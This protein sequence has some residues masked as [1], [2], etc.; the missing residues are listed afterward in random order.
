MDNIKSALRFP[1]PP[2]PLPPTPPQHNLSSRFSADT[3][4]VKSPPGAKTI[5]R[6][7]NHTSNAQPQSPPLR[8]FSLSSSSNSTTRPKHSPS[9][10]ESF[11]IVPSPRMYDFEVAP[12][13][14]TSFDEAEVLRSPT[15]VAS[16]RKELARE[17]SGADLGGVIGVGKDRLAGAAKEVLEV[18]ARKRQGI[19]HGRK[20]SSSRSPSPRK[21]SVSPPSQN[22]NLP[23][24]SSRPSIDSGGGGGIVARKLVDLPPRSDSIAGTLIKNSSP[25]RTRVAK[26]TPSPPKPSKPKLRP[27]SPPSISIPPL[28][29]H[30]RRR[31]NPTLPLVDRSLPPFDAL[32]LSVPS[33][34]DLESRNSHEILVQIDVGGSSHTTTVDTLVGGE[35]KG[36]RL[37]QLV[38]SKIGEIKRE[39]PRAG[40]KENPSYLSLTKF[41]VEDED[42][43]LHSGSS[44]NITGSH[45]EVSP[46]PSPFPFMRD[47]TSSKDDEEDEGN[48][49]CSPIDPLAPQLFLSMPSF[50]APPP[51]LKLDLD[52]LPASRQVQVVPTP[53]LGSKHLSV[54]PTISSNSP[55]PASA[56]SSPQTPSLAR[57]ASNAMS[58]RSFSYHDLPLSP[59]EIAVR[60]ALKKR[61]H[62]STGSLGFNY[63][64]GDDD[65]S[66]REPFFQLLQNQAFEPLP[67]RPGSP[68]SFLHLQNDSPSRDAG[69]NG[70]ETIVFGDSVSRAKITEESRPRPSVMKVETRGEAPSSEASSSTRTRPPSLTTSESTA[71]TDS[72]FPPSHAP[73]PSTSTIPRLHVFLDRT[74]ITLPSGLGTTYSTILSFLRDGVLPP[75]LTLPPP[76][77]PTAKI[78]STTLSIL[79]VQPALAFGQLAALRTVETEAKWVEIDSLVEACAAERQKWIEALRVVE[80]DR[81]I[82]DRSFGDTKRKRMKERE[83]EGWI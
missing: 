20:G 4:A 24:K 3:L 23:E 28:N 63:E 44:I 75:F 6:F 30:P 53:S 1:H 59:D 56:S 79:A 72:D 39:G 19:A 70:E 36:G 67:S 74:D 76:D 57:R 17:L 8:R 33:R 34:R 68:R 29:P 83:L 40:Q 46:N 10:S 60:R 38:V 25:S 12:W 61:L 42:D 77:D 18:L 81:V 82:R 14:R 35:S 54:H 27:N 15:V 58:P 11:I 26:T 69:N 5:Q 31:G 51:P 48:D 50:T 22:T 52:P 2:P 64:G 62:I 66:D 49:C 9:A 71:P 55:V 37:G 13:T 16:R 80:E 47:L 41:A 21:G 45:F 43:G 7:F 32:V 73:L 78:D 65:E